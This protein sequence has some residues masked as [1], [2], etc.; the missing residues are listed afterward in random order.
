MEDQKVHSFIVN[1][2]LI[3][4]NFQHLLNA[5]QREWI[6]VNWNGF[7]FLEILIHEC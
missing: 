5:Q 2:I 7:R 6:E 3:L 4:I 1:T